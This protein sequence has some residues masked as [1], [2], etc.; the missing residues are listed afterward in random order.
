MEGGGQ[1]GAEE[2]DK[3]LQHA[4]GAADWRQQ[5]GRKRRRRTAEAKGQRER[6]DPYDRTEKE[7][8][9]RPGAGPGRHHREAT[10]ERQQ[11]Q[12]EATGPHRNRGQPRATVTEPAA[13]TA[14]GEH[15][16]G[17]R[18]GG[19]RV[20]GDGHGPAEPGPGGGGGRGGGGPQAGRAV[21]AATAALLILYLNAQSIV[22]KMGELAACAAELSPDLILICESW[23]REDI[24]DAF[25][26]LPGYELIPDLRKDRSDT[27]N[28]VGGGL[29]VYA[30]QGL[31]ILS[32]DSGC[33]FNQHCSFRIVTGPEHINITLLY[34]P[35]SA[36]PESIDS[37]CERIRTCTGNNIFIGDFNLPGIDWDTFQAAGRAANLVETCS[38]NFFEQ[39]VDFPTHTKG[40]TLDLILTNVPDKL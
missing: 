15:P 9:P 32:L 17:G 7:R 29:L 36:G 19:G 40:N 28:G 2:A 20:S 30:K 31:T 25:L 35:P 21:R 33:N 5:Q 27:V 34:R 1:E 37:I 11:G 39:L 8:P 6:L 23:C 4:T 10:Q 12:G 26:Q 3:E 18:R 22:G 38:D 14:R 16:H 13:G 24:S